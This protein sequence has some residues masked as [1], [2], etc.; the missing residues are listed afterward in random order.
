MFISSAYAQTAA[1]ATGGPTDLLIQ[2][3]PFV[4]VLAIMYFLLLRPQQQRAKQH[5]ETMK[6]AR[7]GDVIVT[8]G[9]LVARVTK[10]VDDVEVEAEIAPGVRVRLVRA[11][12][13]EIRSKGEPAKDAPDAKA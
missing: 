10:A 9:G 8:T 7:R 12:I 4:G 1:G 6:A 3:V 5:A 11:M 13:S 2:V